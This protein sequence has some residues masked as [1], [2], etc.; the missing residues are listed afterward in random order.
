MVCRLV[1]SD[2]PTETEEAVVLPQRVC[3]S[4]CLCSP[5]P[6]PPCLSLCLSRCL[7]TPF[8]TDF[9]KIANGMR[10]LNFK[11]REVNS[12]R[13]PPSSPTTTPAF[14]PPLLHHRQSSSSKRL[15]LCVN[16]HTRT[17]RGLFSS[18]SKYVPRCVVAANARMQRTRRQG[19]F[20][21]IPLCSVCVRNVAHPS[22]DPVVS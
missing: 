20:T 18:R 19:R 3:L 14:P 21:S 8:E 1:R 6:I 9:A 15:E 5:A 12:C 7:S 13:A 22:P 16:T 11:L 2:Q 4:A 17:H 10:G